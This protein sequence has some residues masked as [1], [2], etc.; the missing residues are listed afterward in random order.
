M[1][2]DLF[3][4]IA[5]IPFAWMGNMRLL[6]Q[7]KRGGFSLIELAIVVMILAIIAGIVI[8]LAGG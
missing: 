2:S 4:G 1:H 5:L 6:N 3:A 8:P 7:A